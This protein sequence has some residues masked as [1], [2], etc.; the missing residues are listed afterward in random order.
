LR[1]RVQQTQKDTNKNIFPHNEVARNKK[2]LNS[3]RQNLVWP[4]PSEA[5]SSFLTAHQ[6]TKNTIS[7]PLNGLETKKEKFLTMIKRI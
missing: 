2:K 6:H 3:T 1:H 4:I 7:L 5:V